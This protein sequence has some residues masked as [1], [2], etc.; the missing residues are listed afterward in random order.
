MGVF[1]FLNELGLN[2]VQAGSQL[3]VNCPAC[4]DN[5]GHLYLA[6]GNGVG[7]CHKC[8]WSPNPYKLTEKVTSKA[9][10]EIMKILD[11][12]GLND[13]D[14]Q[15]SDVRNQKSETKELALNKDEIRALTDDEKKRFCE[16]KQIDAE[17]FERFKPY[18]HKE[19]PW[20]LL[21][22][23]NPNEPNK[24]CGWLRCR[25]DGKLIELVDGRQ[26]KYPIIAGSRHG[27]FALPWLKSQK[28]ETIVFTEGWRDALAAISIGL[29]ATASSGGASCFNNDWLSFFEG[30]TVYIC[31]D[32]DIP[33]QKAAQRAADRIFAVAK[34][35]YIV[36]LPYEITDDHG[37]D[38]RDYISEHGKD[39]LLLLSKAEKYVADIEERFI[40]LSSGQ[41]K[42][43]DEGVVVLDN[44]HPDII[45]TAFIA[46]SDVAYRYNSIDGWSIFSSGKY[47]TSSGLDQTQS[48]L[49]ISTET[50]TEG[51]KK[52]NHVIDPNAGK[53]CHIDDE[54]EIGVYIRRFIKRCYYKKQTRNGKI[55]VRVRPSNNRIKDI[56]GAMAAL[57]GVHIRPQLHAPA[58]LTGKYNPKDIIAMNNSLLDI[59]GNEPKEIPLSEEFYTFNYLP[60][61]YKPEAECPEWT[62]FLSQIFTKKKESAEWD[63]EDFVGKYDNSADG[64]AIFIIQEWMGYFITSETHLQKIFAIVGPKR[65]G[66]STIGKVIR[67]LV[68]PKNTASPTLTSLATEFGL[69]PLLNKTIGIIGDANISGKASDILRAVERLKSISGEDS[70]Q[71]NRKNKTH[72]EVGRLI[73]RFVII[74]N[75]MQDLRDSSGALASRFNFLVTTE[76]F[77]G[78]EDMQLEQK[79][80]KELAGIFNWALEGLFRLRK[81]GFMLEHPA[82]K[83]SRADFEAVSSPMTAFVNEWCQVGP[84]KWVPVDALWKAQSGWCKKNGRGDGFSKQKFALKIKSVVPGIVKERR[85]LELSTLEAEYT[86]DRSSGDN[87]VH[88][89]MGIDLKDEYKTRVDSMDKQDRGWTP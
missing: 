8:G 43:G 14:E 50:V 13:S 20:V 71:V 7:Y 21:P 1:D 69:Q 46:D 57:E 22:A 49:D 16:I 60:F 70:Q 9:P 61:D 53:Y 82:S 24:A 38:L 51:V 72:L 34:A 54:N 48:G 29:F 67:A 4:E 66:K 11:E 84:D 31:M 39:F 47:Q 32:A 81:R 76:S 45:A 83:E 25:L 17:A 37:K 88:V 65:S 77:L 40:Q 58:S 44:D 35:V 62:K 86:M 75:E 89:Y 41:A 19:K 3:R 10:A 55:I 74:A 27:L 33:G 6:P 2:P 42:C 12:F 79:L 5:K 85:R 68:G 73:T 87:R 80:I 26:V 63:G 56:L 64:T 18:A 28:P 78:R 15:K 30:K 52:S 23:F 59:S 36:S